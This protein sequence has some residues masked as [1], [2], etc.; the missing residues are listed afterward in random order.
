MRKKRFA[1]YHAAEHLQQFV[2]AAFTEPTVVHAWFKQ[3]RKDLKGARVD[4]LIARM[5]TLV[6]NSSGE[7]QKTLAGQRRLFY[8]RT[9]TPATQ[10]FTGESKEATNW[11]WGD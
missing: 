8:H 6:E 3:A 9:K 5:Q 10:L 1:F 2:Q 4:H 11:Q 7:R